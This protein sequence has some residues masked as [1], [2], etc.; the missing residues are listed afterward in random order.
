M[1]LNLGGWP[2]N[3]LFG[4]LGG[5]LGAFLVSAVVHII[6][7]W[8]LGRGGNT[9]VIFSFWMMNGIEVMLERIWAKATGRRAGGVWTFGWL[10]LWGVRMVDE[11]AKP[12]R[13]GV[14]SLPVELLLALV[15]FVRRCLEEIVS[16]VHIPCEYKR[17]ERLTHSVCTR[18][19]EGERLQ[20]DSK[21]PTHLQPPT[22]DAG[23]EL[24]RLACTGCLVDWLP[25]RLKEASAASIVMKLVMFCTTVQGAGYSQSPLV[26]MA[27]S[28]KNPSPRCF[29]GITNRRSQSFTS[30]VYYWT[31]SWMD[32]R[33]VWNTRAW[34][35]QEFFASRVVRFYTEDWKLYRPDE[36]LYN[37]KDSRAI[38]AEMAR[39]TGTDKLCFAATR[40]ATKQEDMAYSLFGIFHVSNPVTYGEGQQR[41]VGR[42]LQ[43][44]LTRS[45]DVSILAWTVKAS[46]YNSCLPAEISVYRQPTSPYFPSPI[47]DGKMDQL[48]TG[49]QKSSKN[50]EPAMTLYG[51]VVVLPSPRLASRRLS[52]SCIVFPLKVLPF[53]DDV[54]PSPVDEDSGDGDSD[55]PF[56]NPLPPS[57]YTAPPPHHTPQLDRLT[58]ALRLFSPR[59]KSIAACLFM[60]LGCVET[61][62]APAA[63]TTQTAAHNPSD[64]REPRYRTSKMREFVEYAIAA[65]EK[66]NSTKAGSTQVHDGGLRTTVKCLDSVLFAHEQ[67]HQHETLSDEGHSK[68]A[69]DALHIVSTA[70]DGVKANKP[71]MT[72]NPYE[73]RGLTPYNQ[74]STVEGSLGSESW[75]TI[76]NT[77]ASVDVHVALQLTEV[78]SLIPL[79]PPSRMDMMGVG[80][81]RSLSTRL[82]DPYPPLTGGDDR[83]YASPPREFD[84]WRYGVVAHSEQSLPRRGPGVA[85]DLRL[86]VKRLREDNGVPQY[87]TRRD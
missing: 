34:A 82:T 17:N 21:S 30:K 16:T 36:K 3:C 15:A 27:R 19:G 18:H 73:F 62:Y 64:R 11:W 5:V 38:M 75:S 47:E 63:M 25:V 26:P 1:V 67:I 53:E 69:V 57:S 51:R 79:P 10:T 13:F 44:V 78:S 81:R 72:R 20:H 48:V 46:E 83:G 14:R 71:I 58:R 87:R 32:W 65:F 43:E 40:V 42:L 8:S 52:L 50:V 39:A 86:P 35:L 28:F 54:E 59:D 60:Q 12:G 9:A 61:C 85:E 22:R 4:R 68:A 80:P 6:E 70:G 66:L 2:F 29:N 76:Q 45:G 56:T 49:L 31:Q 74:T 77:L 23:L 37:H 55:A 7:V 24:C 41:A 33:G 84:R